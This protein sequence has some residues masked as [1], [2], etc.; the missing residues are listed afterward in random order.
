MLTLAR[1]VCISFCRNVNV[2]H[3]RYLGLIG[4]E[5]VQLCFCCVACYK[6]GTGTVDSVDD[7]QEAAG[8]SYGLKKKELWFVILTI[9]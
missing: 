7:K 3:L 6:E 2:K 4:A 8:F 1:Q 9:M 5:E